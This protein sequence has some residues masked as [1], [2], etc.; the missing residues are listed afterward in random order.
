MIRS[1]KTK[2]SDGA[3]GDSYNLKVDDDAMQLEMDITPEWL[4]DAK[5][6]TS[7]DGTADEADHE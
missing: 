3:F 6:G 1:A 2:A 5:T 7:S 4:D